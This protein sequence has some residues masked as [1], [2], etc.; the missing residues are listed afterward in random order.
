MDDDVRL[1]VCDVSDYR[2]EKTKNIKKTSSPIR[3][4]RTIIIDSRVHVYCVVRVIGL[5]EPIRRIDPLKN[6]HYKSAWVIRVQVIDIIDMYSVFIDI[7]TY[8]FGLEN[9]G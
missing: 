7:Y 4:R 3:C 6:N 8:L 1:C 5:C 9:S 2:V